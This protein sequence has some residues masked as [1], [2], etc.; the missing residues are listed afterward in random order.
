MIYIFAAAIISFCA[1]TV[2]AV[3]LVSTDKMPKKIWWILT[4]CTYKIWWSY[5]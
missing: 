2:L 3:N 5:L 1:G 4:C